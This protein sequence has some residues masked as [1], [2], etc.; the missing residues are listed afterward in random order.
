MSLCKDLN[1]VNLKLKMVSKVTAQ[2]V[3]NIKKFSKILNL[4]D[5]MIAVR[6]SRVKLR[7]VK[8]VEIK[9][10]LNKK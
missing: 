6:D 9:E 2:D 8:F 7:N 5:V 1:H 10:N 4:R 3:S